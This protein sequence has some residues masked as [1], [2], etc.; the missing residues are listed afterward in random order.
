MEHALDGINQVLD[1]E[2]A[3]FVR[4]MGINVLST[5]LSMVCPLAARAAHGRIQLSES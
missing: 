1:G 4:S 3:S 2:I 5:S